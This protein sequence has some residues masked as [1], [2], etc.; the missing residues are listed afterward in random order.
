MRNTRLVPVKSDGRPT[1]L[2]LF[3]MRSNSPLVWLG[4]KN[5]DELRQV[6]GLELATPQQAVDAYAQ[7]RNATNVRV[8]L[9]RDGQPLTLRYELVEAPGR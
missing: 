7:I 1:G 9:I 4:F 5:G 8:E 2:R 3:G 6:N